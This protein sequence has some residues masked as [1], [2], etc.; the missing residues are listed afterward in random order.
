MGDSSQA[1]IVNNVLGD[2]QR[3]GVA[4]GERPCVDIDPV[5]IGY[6]TGRGNTGGGNAEGDYCPEDLTFLFTEKGGE[7]DRRA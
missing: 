6:V 3:F 4:L 7:L 1:T 5:F 2:N